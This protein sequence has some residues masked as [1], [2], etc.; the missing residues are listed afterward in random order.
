MDKKTNN[1]G[2]DETLSLDELVPKATRY[3]TIVGS[4]ARLLATL[5]TF[6]TVII[7]LL[8]T[9]GYVLSSDFTSNSAFTFLSDNLFSALILYSILISVCVFFQL[10]MFADRKR[11]HNREVEQ[12]LIFRRKSFPFEVRVRDE[13]EFD[14]LKYYF[15]L[16]NYDSFIQKILIRKNSDYKNSLEN[17]E[18]ILTTSNRAAQRTAINFSKS[19]K[20][21]RYLKGAGSSIVLLPQKHEENCEREIYRNDEDAY[22]DDWSSAFGPL[23]SA[24]NTRE[25]LLIKAEIGDAKS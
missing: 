1:E 11:R 13:V 6:S 9:I 16:D 19:G 21:L 12:S 14:I 4:L 3:V 23:L 25:Q 20:L 18:N 10:I 2:F 22:N 7:F 5:A 8:T 17:I 15:E 24:I